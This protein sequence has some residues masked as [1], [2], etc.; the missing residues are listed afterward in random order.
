MV[1]HGPPAGARERDQIR[2][3]DRIAERGVGVGQWGGWT[4]GALSPCTGVRP[5]ERP[6]LQLPHDGHLTTRVCLGWG[7]TGGEEASVRR[8]W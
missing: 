7:C 1:V 3:Q 8:V 5:C 2:I 6:S 4:R